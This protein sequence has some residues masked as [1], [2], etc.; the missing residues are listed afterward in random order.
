MKCE[1]L[2]IKGDW[3]EVYEAALATEGKVPADPDKEP[4]SVWKYKILKAEHS[5]I[6]LIRVK[7]KWTDIPYWVMNHIRTHHVALWHSDTEHFSVSS[8]SD[9]TGIN[10]DELLQNAP[11]DY[12]LEAKEWF[13]Y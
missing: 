6:R 9:R 4:S 10:R 1:I 2:K 3:K 7:V 12:I 11:V 5:P 8:R 13:G